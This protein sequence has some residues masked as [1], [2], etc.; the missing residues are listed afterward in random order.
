MS[1]ITTAL[2]NRAHTKA[3]RKLHHPRKR[4]SAKEGEASRICC[5]STTTYMPADSGVVGMFNLDFECWFH[6]QKDRQSFGR[7]SKGRAGMQLVA[8]V[9]LDDG[10]VRMRWGEE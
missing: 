10:T 9:L 5:Q 8:V 4:S 7:L 2:P 1:V 6:L 3:C